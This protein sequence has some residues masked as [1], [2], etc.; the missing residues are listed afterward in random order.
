MERVDVERRRCDG[1]SQCNTCNELWYHRKSSQVLSIWWPQE[2]SCHEPFR[3]PCAHADTTNS[4]NFVAPVRM[5]TPPLECVVGQGEVIFVPRGW[6]HAC[7]NLETMTIAGELKHVFLCWTVM[8]SSCDICYCGWTFA[9]S[10][11]ATSLFKRACLKPSIRTA[12]L[13]AAACL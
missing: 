8:R 1:T 5:Q 12:C 2:L 10:S 6:W 11:L 4:T 3:R 13:L 9:G 7:L